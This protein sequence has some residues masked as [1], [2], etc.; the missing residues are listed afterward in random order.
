LSS[1]RC[2]TYHGCSAAHG[3]GLVEQQAAE[4]AGSVHCADQ[5]RRDA[6]PPLQK[7]KKKK[8]EKG[9]NEQEKGRWSEN[10]GQGEDGEQARKR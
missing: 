4:A 1:G 5:P 3:I 7:K 6:R 2:I 9:E 10:K 8:K